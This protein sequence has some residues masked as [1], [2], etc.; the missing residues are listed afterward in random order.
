MCN[1]LL[2][3]ESI[4]HLYKMRHICPNSLTLERA[5]ERSISLLQNP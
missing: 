3:Y 2:P 5:L 4:L 1:Y